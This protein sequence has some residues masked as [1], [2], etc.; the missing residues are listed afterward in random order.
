LNGCTCRRTRRLKPGSGASSTR[1][2]GA[3]ATKRVAREVR[4]VAAATAETT[5]EQLSESRKSFLTRFLRRHPL[6]KLKVAVGYVFTFTAARA[7]AVITAAASTAQRLRF[8]ASLILLQD[9]FESVKLRLRPA[10]EPS[11][12]RCCRPG[13]R[14]C[15]A[16]ALS[17]TAGRTP[18]LHKSVDDCPQRLWDLTKGL[19]PRQETVWSCFQPASGVLRGTSGIHR[20]ER[21]DEANARWTFVAFAFADQPQEL[22]Q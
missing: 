9:F 15:I 22:T 3:R 13:S 2:A 11:R 14:C 5:S 19:A 4:G 21:P 12:R 17:S 1:R 6:F 7:V 8:A 18:L 20:A 10:N 16:V